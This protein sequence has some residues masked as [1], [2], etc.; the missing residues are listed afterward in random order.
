VIMAT[1]ISVT[2]PA[3]PKGPTGSCRLTTGIDD[4]RDAGEES[5]D[6][7]L[8]DYLWIARRRA[9]KSIAVGWGSYDLSSPRKVSPSFPCC[10]VLRPRQDFKRR[11]A[12][13][14]RRCTHSDVGCASR[15]AAST[16]PTHRIYIKRNGTQQVSLSNC[17]MQ[18]RA[19]SA[20]PFDLSY[21]LPV[22]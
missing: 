7:A 16:T 22:Q 8:A 5:I 4:S 6:P 13:Q 21:S 12:L 20:N 10:P 3:S 17:P 1:A 19:W 2:N 9:L 18:N 14:N 15:L 11:C